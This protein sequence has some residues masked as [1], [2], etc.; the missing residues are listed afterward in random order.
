MYPCRIYRSA[1]KLL[2]CYR[3]STS[4]RPIVGAH[5][6][7]ATDTRFA[8]FLHRGNGHLILLHLAGAAGHP[9]LTAQAQIPP[10]PK[11]RADQSL[12]SYLTTWTRHLKHHLLVGTVYSDRHYIDTVMTGMHPSLRAQ[13]DSEVSDRKSPY[14]TP[15]P[16]SLQPGSLLATFHGRAAELGHPKYTTMTPREL[17]DASQP[18]RMLGADEAAIHALHTP[19]L[20]S[21]CSDPGHLLRDCLFQAKLN[22]PAI[23]KSI[24]LPALKHSLLQ[25]SSDH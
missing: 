13:F 4:R 24:G 20:C 8:P 7:L 3:F 5:S 23:R 25:A 19:R 11:Q 10:D 12:V 1:H 6:G 21:L 2:A 14:G 16:A 22:D 15:L 9:L 17:R 18:V